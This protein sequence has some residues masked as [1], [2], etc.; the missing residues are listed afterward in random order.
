MKHLLLGLLLLPLSS[1][2]EAP[3]AVVIDPLAVCKEG[4]CTMRE[5][6]YKTLRE[7]HSARWNALIEAGAELESLEAQN[8]ELTRRLVR[9]A[10]HRCGSRI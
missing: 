9:L 10:A 4:K 2:A 6:D 8:A 5:E 3:P 7:F 1:I